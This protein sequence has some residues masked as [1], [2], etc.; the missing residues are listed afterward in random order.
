MLT[1]DQPAP[2]AEW[3]AFAVLC[4]TGAAWLVAVLRCLP[5][6]RVAILSVVFVALLIGIVV[7]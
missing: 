5:S 4:V 1:P 3:I 2:L 7:W 6:R